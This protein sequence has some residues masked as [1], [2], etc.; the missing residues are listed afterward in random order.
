MD[1]RV[2]KIGSAPILNRRESMV[3]AI[4]FVGV[5]IDADDDAADSLSAPHDSAHRDHSPYPSFRGQHR[6][7]MHCALR[8]PITRFLLPSLALSQA[9]S[10]A[11]PGRVGESAKRVCS[12][13]VMGRTG[14][15]DAILIVSAHKK[16]L[17]LVDLEGIGADFPICSGVTIEG[18]K[19]TTTKH[20]GE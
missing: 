14:M 18:A 15:S 6:P 12:S 8:Q 3:D 1:L 4:L 17:F 16:S 7:V 5:G 20:P 11:P 19:E 9:P 2:A 10:P 13:F